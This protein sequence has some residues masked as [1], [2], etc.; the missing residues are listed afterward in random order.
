ME[1]TRNEDAIQ[2]GPAAHPHEDDVVELTD[3][4]LV[5]VGGGVGEVGL[6]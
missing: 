5:A 4:Q 1:F 6:G 2:R 3:V